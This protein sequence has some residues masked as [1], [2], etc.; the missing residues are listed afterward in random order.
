MKRLIV[1]ALQVEAK[2][3]IDYFGLR[4]DPGSSPISTYTNESTGNIYLRGFA[5]LREAKEFSRKDAETQRGLAAATNCS[6]LSVVKRSLPM[7]AVVLGCGLQGIAAA[8][9]LLRHSEATQLLLTDARASQLRATAKHL[10]QL[11]PF[12]RE[13]V[14]TK[15]LVEQV[16]L[17]P[18]SDFFSEILEAYKL[19]PH[20]ISPNRSSKPSSKRPMTG[21]TTSVMPALPVIANSPAVI[22]K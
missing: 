18:P 7:K 5:P 14:I 1:V 16:F 17:F 11:L 21:R 3:L 2:P 4:K 12:H 13:R 9:D 20:N 22:S 6:G 10:T 15:V 8:Y 19:Q